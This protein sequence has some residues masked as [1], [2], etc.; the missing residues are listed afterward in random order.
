MVVSFWH[1]FKR[2][3]SIHTINTF[4]ILQGTLCLCEKRT[5]HLEIVF[6]TA[7]LRKSEKWPNKEFLINK[8]LLIYLQLVTGTIEQ[9][10]LSSHEYLQLWQ[11]SPWCSSW[12]FTGLVNWPSCC[13]A[14]EFCCIFRFINKFVPNNF[15]MQN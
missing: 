2:D 3:S 1:G 11:D 6:V 12:P 5:K 8:T 13:G 14:K 4:Y 10:L 7:A 15:W 9:F